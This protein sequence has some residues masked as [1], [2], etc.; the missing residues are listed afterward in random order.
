MIELVK[1]KQNCCGC[2]A[3]MSI[4]PTL[5]IKME[6]DKEG[7]LYPTIDH[8]LCIEC[9]RCLNV[10]AFQNGY[11]TSHNL[12]EPVAFAVKHS[13]SDVREQSTSGGIFSAISDVVLRNKGSVYGAA[14]DANLIVCHQKATT[15]DERDAL[16]GSK[17]VQSEM[18]QTIHDIEVD[19]SEGKKVL[20]T[21]TPCQVA[22]VREFFI[23]KKISTENLVLCDII[24]HGTPS[25]LIFSQYLNLCE[26][27]EKKKITNHIFRSKVLGWH[28]HTEVNVFEDGQT[29]SKSYVSQLFKHIFY[30]H[31][32]LRPACHNCKYTSLDRASDITIADYWGIDRFLPEFDDNKG[33]SL[34]LLNTQ[35]GLDY[36][37]LC[38]DKLIVRDG[39]ARECLYY[40]MNQ[41]T[42]ASPLRDSIWN[43]YHT[44][45]FEYIIKKYYSYGIKGYPKRFVIYTLKKLNLASMIK[46]VLGR[47]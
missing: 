44:K 26:K 10:C 5:A 33:I 14:F 17:Y 12:F 32:I 41:P 6:P 31:A 9:E 43:D 21:G 34:A 28:N 11:D 29:D 40:N 38:R 46:K 15:P 27:T 4:C 42:K 16:R 2:S 35:K 24:C 37:D 25:P 45:G 36:F 18:R 22:G 19:L 30:S 23:T 47:D 3:C 8:T 20:F 1:E 13:S 39:N 7:F